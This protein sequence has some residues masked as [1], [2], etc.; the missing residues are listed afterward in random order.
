MQSATTIIFNNK[1]F[2]EI[3]NLYI[4]LDFLFDVK[5]AIVAKYSVE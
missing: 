2:L 3:E 4:F 5:N 1:R